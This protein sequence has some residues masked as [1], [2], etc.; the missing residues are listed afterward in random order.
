MNPCNTPH[1]SLHCPY[2]VAVF[3]ENN[4]TSLHLPGSIYFN[5]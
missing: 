3:V 4:I 2:I 1:S 5:T